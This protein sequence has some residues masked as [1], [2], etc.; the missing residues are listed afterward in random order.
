MRRFVGDKPRTFATEAVDQVREAAQLQVLVLRAVE[1]A[2]IE[3]ELQAAQHL[4][5]AGR[6]IE[7]GE[8]AN[9]LFAR[10]EAKARDR[11]KNFARR[12]R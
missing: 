9:D 4:L 10:H 8:I 2:M 3:E 12:D 1:I 5:A 6:R 7:H 11:A